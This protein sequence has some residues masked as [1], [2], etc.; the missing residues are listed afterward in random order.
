M[1]GLQTPLLQLDCYLNYPLFLSPGKTYPKTG[2]AVVVHYTGKLHGSKEKEEG[3]GVERVRGRREKGRREEGE[4][5][6]Q[7]K[8]CASS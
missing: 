1:S 8:Y 7:Y 2:Q 6:A 3:G 5:K 4:G